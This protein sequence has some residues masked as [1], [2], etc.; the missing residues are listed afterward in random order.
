MISGPFDG[1]KN[2]DTIFAGQT[3]QLPSNGN[4]NITWD[5]DP[6]LSCTDCPNPIASPAV[7]TVYTA[8]NSLANDCQLS[9]RFT[10]VVLKD[11][12]TFMPT[13]FTPNGDGL[14]DWFGPIGKSAQ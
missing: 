12:V 13:A 6:T 2:I 10:L 11:A 9:D 3:L 1:I 5:F 14:N 8:T 7:T 4:G